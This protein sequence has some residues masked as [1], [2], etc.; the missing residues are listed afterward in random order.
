MRRR[1]LAITA[2]IVVTALAGIVTSH[3]RR[4]IRLARNRISS[5]S[6]MLRTPCGD[7]EYADAGRGPAVLMVHGAG[8][9]FDQGMAF[10]SEFSTRGFHVISMS[11]FGYLRTPLPAD[12]SAQAQADAHVCL[13]DALG[14]EKAAVIGASA[15]APSSMQLAL[16]HPDR[17]SALVLLVPATFAPRPNN[18][19]PLTTPPGTEFLFSTALKSDFLF[20][21]ARHAVPHTMVRSILATPPEDLDKVNE[22]ERERVTRMLDEILPVSPRRLGLLNDAKITSSLVRYDL[23]KIAT[24]TLI[25]SVADDQFGTFAGARY[26]AE[27]IP[28]AR[29]V[30]YATG[31]HIWAGHHTDL[32]SEIS[33]F[34]KQ[35][36]GPVDSSAKMRAKEPTPPAPATRTRL[37]ALT[38]R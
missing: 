4:E 16:R 38:S 32:V 20:W 23:E 12:A 30:G 24:P 29:F 28:N 18:A 3:Y 7:I 6:R 37:A 35:A 19:P 31:G 22:A 8:G 25:I 33:V 2:G 5:G 14:I 1:S 15:G 13:M 36:L 11:R 27:H 26:S 34:L 21:A 9:G 17:V 10:S